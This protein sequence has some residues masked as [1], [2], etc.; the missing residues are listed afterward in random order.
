MVDENQMK[1]R[2]SDMKKK[3]KAMGSNYIQSRLH[4]MELDMDAL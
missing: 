3:A 4:A 1:I 2:I